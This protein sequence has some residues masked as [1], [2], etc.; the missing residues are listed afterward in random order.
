MIVGIWNQKNEG[1]IKKYNH[2]EGTIE[3]LDLALNQYAVSFMKLV[4]NLGKKFIYAVDERI[5]DENGKIGGNILVY[6]LCKKGI[7]QIQETNVT[8]P[9]YLDIVEK[10]NILVV[11]NYGCSINNAERTDSELAVYKRE[12][13][14]LIKKKESWRYERE[15]STA[16][17]HSA[18][19]VKTFDCI[20]VSDM[21]NG[22]LHV[23][24]Y[25]NET[26]HK[27]YSVNAK[28]NGNIK[29][30]YLVYN[31]KN[32]CIYVSDEKSW[33]TYMYKF[34]N[35]KLEFFSREHLLSEE[36]DENVASKQS[37]IWVSESLNKLYVCSRTGRL[38]SIFDID[39]EGVLERVQVFCVNG[40]PRNIAIDYSNE[41]CYVSCTKDNKIFVFK[42]DSRGLFQGIKD[43]IEIKAPAPIL[44]CD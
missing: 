25:E 11:V 44:I 4:D 39:E 32:H 23:L 8:L 12:T 19:F 17:F 7:I 40:A 35:G 18:I 43:T 9:C 5:M 15:F 41:N 28:E 37:D 36:A 31:E 21:G 6:D 24:R 26:M 33:Y 20:I 29:P 1:G 42:L 2:L 13:N 22:L 34:R 27:M 30:R 14:G 38:I 10:Y 3:D 16:H